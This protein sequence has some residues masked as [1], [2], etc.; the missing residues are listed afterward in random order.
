M[1]LLNHIP[2][3]YVSEDSD[4]SLR[5]VF[6]VLEALQGATLEASQQFPHKTKQAPTTQF[7]EEWLEEVGNPFPLEN[8]TTATRR[9]LACQL[10]SMYHRRGSQSGLLDAIRFFLGITPSLQ[11][12]YNLC[13]RL[14]ISKLGRSTI[15]YSST[16]SQFSLSYPSPLTQAQRALLELIVNFFKPMHLKCVINIPTA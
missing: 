8:L 14:G 9:Q 3:A 12:D 6:G 2:G 16:N 11:M 4:E 5:K 15:I 1:P 13:W 10:V 7:V